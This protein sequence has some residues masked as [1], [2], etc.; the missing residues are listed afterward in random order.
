MGIFIK[1][2]Q[3]NYIPAPAVSHTA[4]C[5]YVLYLALK[6]T[7]WQGK[8]KTLPKVAFVFQIGKKTD[9]GKPFTVWVRFTASFH[10]KSK[11]TEALKIWLGK[12]LSDQEKDN[13]D[14]ETLVGKP[15]LI[16]VIHANKNGSVF[17]NISSIIPLPDGLVPPAIGDYVRI[18][19][20]DKDSKNDESESA[21]LAE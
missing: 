2:Q 19:D 3:N 11:L 16:S 18:K 4:V 12:E 8:E 20:R 1:K 5:V 13:L 10:K 14:L 15:A 7:V 6:T 21:V 9:D 17:A